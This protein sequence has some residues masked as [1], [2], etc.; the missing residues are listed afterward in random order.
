MIHHFWPDGSHMQSI[1]NM[2]VKKELWVP[3]RKLVGKTFLAVKNYSQGIV[4]LL[5][6][7]FFPRK[8][9]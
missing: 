2:L 8:D 1:A 4:E 9:C 3:Y 5:T 7:Y 6:S